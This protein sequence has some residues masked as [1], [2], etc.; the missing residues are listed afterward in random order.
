M[1]SAL[2]SRLSFRRPDSPHYG[3]RECCNSCRVWCC[4]LQRSF[5][6]LY[7]SFVSFISL[8]LMF[9]LLY[10]PWQHLSRSFV[11]FAG[12]KW[13][14]RSCQRFLQFTTYKQFCDDTKVGEMVIK[15]VEGAME[16]LKADIEKAIVDAMALTK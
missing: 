9:G 13:P 6:V 16:V 3:S 1:Y 15:N 7:N 12:L 14:R 4:S 8:L 5:L 11:F 2:V 10:L